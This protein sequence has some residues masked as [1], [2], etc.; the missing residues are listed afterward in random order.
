MRIHPEVGMLR[1]EPERPEMADRDG[2]GLTP[3]LT[4][5]S[6]PYSEEDAEPRGVF[7][8]VDD[9][10]HLVDTLISLGVEQGVTVK[11]VI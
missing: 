8:P 10:R 11:K 5:I 1:S 9:Q 2:T 4:G 6:A 3:A 7:D